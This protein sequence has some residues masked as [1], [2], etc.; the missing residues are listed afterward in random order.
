MKVP[1]ALALVF[2]IV[3]HE[4]PAHAAAP[5]IGEAR[6][7]FV[8]A[9]TSSDRDVAL[10]E[11]ALDDLIRKAATLTVGD[12][13][14]HLEAMQKMLKALR[15]FKAEKA[16][17]LA[18][19]LDTQEKLFR[20]AADY[21]LACRV[22]AVVIV[23]NVVVIVVVVAV[24]T[25]A[26]EMAAAVAAVDKIATEMA[27]LEVSVTEL[28]KLI[29]VLRAA[30]GDE[31]RRVRDN[32]ETTQTISRNIQKAAEA[33]ADLRAV[34]TSLHQANAASRDAH[35]RLQ[36]AP[37]LVLPAL[38]TPPVLT[39]FD[40]YLGGNFGIH[41][42]NGRATVGS[43]EATL[44][45]GVTIS[46]KNDPSVKLTLNGHVVLKAHA[47]SSSG[48]GGSFAAPQTNVVTAIA[49]GAGQQGGTWASLEAQGSA[50]ISG[51]G[52]FV[53]T[54][55]NVALQSQ[56]SNVMF[57]GGEAS[58]RGCTH[59]LVAG[60]AFNS[61]QVL[62]EGSL[63]CGHWSLTASSMGID[64]TG[65]SGGGTLS[66]WSKSFAM[67]Y[68][69][70]G[71]VLTARGSLS[72][73]DTLWTRVPGFEVE[74]RIEAPKLDLKLDLKLDG[75]SLSPTFGAGKVSVR[76]T[77]KK[78]DGSPWSS[79]SL[80]PGTVVVPAPPSDGIPVPFPVLPTPSD[81]EKDA[82][83]TCERVAR[84][85]LGGQALQ[86]ALDVCRSG[87]PSPPTLPALPRTPSLKVGDIFR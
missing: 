79:A 72:G 33:L 50:R 57:T 43:A 35:A 9:V 16:R 40:G 77:A 7:R 46:P 26:S 65:V 62:L 18:R 22:L 10:A 82:R 8:A 69:A 73:A 15:D 25:G 48:P 52:P 1:V 87:H 81:L 56:S 80:T 45:G 17:I 29:E 34:V 71:D 60:S 13:Q 66:A 41:L 21:A 86:T 67:S 19:E 84:A 6:R 23:V 64:K 36:A 63:R 42:D 49:G 74:Y 47:V 53:V 51:L 38:P 30:E 14:R 24:F 37:K 32:S 39:S 78:P 75:P 61:S 59:T 4:I 54:I 44:D 31:A 12:H 58:F 2:A 28:I 20:A 3:L 27:T 11:A 55:P 70:S 68:S 83:D 85:T 5:D 76:T